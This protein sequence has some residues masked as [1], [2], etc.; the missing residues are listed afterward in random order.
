ETPIATLIRARNIAREEGLHYVYT[1]N[2]HNIEGDTT[3]CSGCRLPLIV[4]DW[5]QINGYQL[6]SAGCCP[7][8]GTLIA[9]RFDAQ[10]GAFGQ[11]RIPISIN[12]SK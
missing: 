10:A 3:Y 6:T 12:R 7:H 5:Y 1:G 2:V 11:N 4:R 8:C 9:G